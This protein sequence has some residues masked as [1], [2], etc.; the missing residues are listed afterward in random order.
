LD[1]TYDFNISRDGKVFLIHFNGMSDSPKENG[2]VYNSGFYSFTTKYGKLM[3]GI[4]APDMRYSVEAFDKYYYLGQSDFNINGKY[5][6]Y[7]DKV[8]E[9]VYDVT[10]NKLVLHFKYDTPPGPCYGSGLYRLEIAGYNPIFA[11]FF[12]ISRTIMKKI[13]YGADGK[14]IKIEIISNNSFCKDFDK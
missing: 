14:I 3:K 1:N 11:E 6:R 7:P 10:D 4:G 13:I 5:Y 8:D 12:N 2:A 9:K